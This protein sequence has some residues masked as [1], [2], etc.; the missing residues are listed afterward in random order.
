MV[1]WQQAGAVPPGL[2]LCPG[3]GWLLLTLLHAEGILGEKP[4]PH[5]SVASLGETVPLKILREM[6]RAPRTEAPPGSVS[7]GVHT[8]GTGRSRCPRVSLLRLLRTEL[9]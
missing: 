7:T 5:F 1:A 3:S 8:Q 6:G 4:T 2:Y 9:V